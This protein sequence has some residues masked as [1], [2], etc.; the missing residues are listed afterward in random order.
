M[1]RVDV[2][3]WMTLNAENALAATALGFRQLGAL[4]V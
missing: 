2:A 1:V 3:G 4:P